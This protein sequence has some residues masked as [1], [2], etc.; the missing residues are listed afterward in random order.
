MILV[1]SQS[2]SPQHKPPLLPSLSPLALLQQVPAL[3]RAFVLQPFSKTSDTFLV[4]IVLGV[5]F[6]SCR[7]SLTRCR[8]IRLKHVHLFLV[9]VLFRKLTLRRR[10]IQRATFS[11]RAQTTCPGRRDGDGL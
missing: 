5:R 3:E 8:H 6:T 4:G 7:S 10:V 9:Q 1:I 2:S 11:D